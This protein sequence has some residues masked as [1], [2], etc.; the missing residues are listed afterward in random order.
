MKKLIYS[1][2]LLVAMSGCSPT[3]QMT[4]EVPLIDGD[5]F[6]YETIEIVN[7]SLPPDFSLEVRVVSEIELVDDDVWRWVDTTWVRENVGGKSVSLFDKYGRYL[8]IENLSLVSSSLTNK[9][10]KQIKQSILGKTIE[11]WLPKGLRVVGAKL[12]SMGYCY[13]K[14]L[15]SEPPE[16]IKKVKWQGWAV[17]VV[18][19]PSPS[20]VKEMYYERETGFLVGYKIYL[21]HLYGD[22]IVALTDSSLR[23]LLH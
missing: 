16:V 15:F 11:Q 13:P 17:L 20:A 21:G 6:V 22:V 18:S 1:L 8:K 3:G 14:L 23:G 10:L 5:Y 19:L 9:Q 12:S 7:S 4:E 2:V